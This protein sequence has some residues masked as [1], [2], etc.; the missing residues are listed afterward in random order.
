MSDQNMS[1]GPSTSATEPIEQPGSLSATAATPQ[2]TNAAVP[3]EV[4]LPQ[5]VSPATPVETAT[6]QPVSSA[7]PAEPAAQ[8]ALIVDDNWHNRNIFKIALE[9]VG[10]K[11]MESADGVEGIA[12]LENQTFDLLVLDLQMPNVDGRKVLQTVKAQPFHSKMSVLVV[13]ANAHM[14]TDDISNLADYIMY[15]P[16]DVVEFS[17]F[18]SRLKH[19]KEPSQ[20][21]K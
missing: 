11:V 6:S 7:V 18:A 20:P 16:I 8:T 19:S 4:V 2:P 15:K 1:A 12:T 3:A 14:A 17:G 10:Y 21:V 9:S 13:T 5:P